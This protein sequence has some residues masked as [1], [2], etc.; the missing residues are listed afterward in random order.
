MI[1]SLLGQLLGIIS[2]LYLVVNTIF[3]ACLLLAVTVLRLVIP[4]GS[5]RRLCGVMA[6]AIAENWIFFNNQGLLL[7]RKI[8][9]E[10]EGLEQLERNEWYLVMSNHQS[11]VDIP[12]L[13]K[14]F[15]R[16]IPFLKFFLKKELIWVPILGPAWW[17]LDFPFMKRYSAEFIQKNPHLKGKDM[18]ITRKACSKFKEIPVSVMNFVEGTRFSNE[19]LKRQKSPYKNLLRP[20]AGGVGFV[21]SAMG[22]QLS[23]IL[24]VTVSY[25][26]GSQ[27][28]WAFLCG[29][30]K[31]VKV[32]VEKLAITNDVLG[33][34]L[35]DKEYRE[36]FQKW[37]NER[38]LEKDRLLE[39]MKETA[40]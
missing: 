8:E 36:R 10:V 13:Q 3:W 9:F 25:P 29:K 26:Q 18:E 28:F 11:W 6:I 15:Y 23:N 2:L 1:D 39:K 22:D 35:E 33:D 37:L 38:W 19:K 5:W 31:Q 30:V 12:V 16:K 17:A 20:K 14:V 40:E 24:D 4:V 27:E 7:T 34:Y 21:L 32:N